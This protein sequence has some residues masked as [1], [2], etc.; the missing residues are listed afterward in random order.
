MGELRA[1]SRFAQPTV[2][3]KPST[4]IASLEGAL[5][6]TSL[7]ET[8]IEL[9]AVRSSDSALSAFHVLDDDEDVV[10]FTPAI[11]SS[12]SQIMDPFEPLGRALS[13][14]HVRVR[15]V[16]YVPKHGM[17]ETHAAFLEHAGAA[18]VVLCDVPP[19][20]KVAAEL[21]KQQHA[22]A[23]AVGQM[24]DEIPML[25]VL[26]SES[27]HSSSTLEFGTV[28]HVASFS[29]SALR[30]IAQSIFH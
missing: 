25:V 13:K 29:P 10:L 11:R 22:F 16:P 5:K 28:L 26:V 17:T 9:P 8:T 3:S 1:R 12:S 18:V 15:H 27:S 21:Y 24:S 23:R 19:S 20:S 14:H 2:Q 7:D 4:S 30:G 6:Q